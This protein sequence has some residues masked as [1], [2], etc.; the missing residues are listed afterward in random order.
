MGAKLD[1]RPHRRSDLKFRKN[2]AKVG[3]RLGNV[4]DA[5]GE[6]FTLADVQAAAENDPDFDR[7][8]VSYRGSWAL[9][10]LL[11]MKAVEVVE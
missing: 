1:A 7:I 2:G 10:E 11:R 4:L 5:V 8:A 6:E 9:R 3:G